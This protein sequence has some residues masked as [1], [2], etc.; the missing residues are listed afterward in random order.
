MWDAVSGGLQP[1]PWHHSTFGPHLTPFVQDL[2]PTCTGITMKRCTHMPIH[3]ILW[4]SSALYI[5]R[6]MFMTNSLLRYIL[7]LSRRASTGSVTSEAKSVT[8]PV[9]NTKKR[10]L[11]WVRKQGSDH[12]FQPNF[13]GIILR[14]IWVD[15]VTQKWSRGDLKKW[16]FS[17]GPPIIEEQ[18]NKLNSFRRKRLSSI[19][20]NIE[21]CQQMQAGGRMF[22]GHKRRWVWPQHTT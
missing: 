9:T 12:F 3:S 14:A 19:L 6:Y 1:Q 10:W 2:A 7:F 5:C 11:W 13:T 21:H 8:S 22:W 20:S 4:S 16:H 18:N 15:L 17:C